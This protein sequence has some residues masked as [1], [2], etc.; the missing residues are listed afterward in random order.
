MKCRWWGVVGYAL[1]IIGPGNSI[2]HPGV[3]DA[4]GQTPPPPSCTLGA[5]CTGN[6]L[7]QLL[8]TVDALQSIVQNLEAQ[9]LIDKQ[10]AGTLDRQ[11]KSVERAAR[12]FDRTLSGGR[13]THRTVTKLQGEAH[14]LLTLAQSV[15][16]EFGLGQNSSLVSTADEVL[17]NAGALNFREDLP[18]RF[19][20]EQPSRTIPATI[21][22]LGPVDLTVSGSIAADISLLAG[23]ES[24]SVTP[25]FAGYDVTVVPAGGTT[26]VVAGT[27]T[28]DPLA[29][30]TGRLCFTH[31]RLEWCLAL[32]AEFT[33]PE[34]S[35]LTMVVHVLDRFHTITV[36]EVC[37]CLSLEQAEVVSSSQPLPS[38]LSQILT[39]GLFDG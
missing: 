32:R 39:A 13:D 29:S 24:A 35:T 37:P 31:R 30:S 17:Q 12:Q 5:T 38:G 6:V 3:H 23:T 15:A 33:V 27:I 4:L 8:S 26:P 28:L 16:Q 34:P 11:A 36:P 14:D 10:G 21:P 22:G 25:L 9:N 18:R 7:G 2:K 1:L 19:A 20:F